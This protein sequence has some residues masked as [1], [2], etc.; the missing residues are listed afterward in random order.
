MNRLKLDFSLET[1]KERADFIEHYIIQFPDLTAKEASTI[2]DYLLWGKTDDGVALGAGVGLETKW[3]RPKEA[4]SL[5]A[6]LENPALTNIQ[7]H[8]LDDA[9]VFKKNR[10]VF[11]RK[12]ARKKAPEFLKQAFEDLWKSIDETELEINFYEERVGKREKP[13]RQELLDRFE[14]K[15]IERIRARSQKLNQYKYLKLRHKLKELRTEQFV[16]RDSY[17]PTFNITQSILTFKDKTAAFDCDIEV[18]PLGIKEGEIGEVI[19]DLNFNPDLL[20]EKQLQQISKLIWAKK[21]NTKSEK[22]T[23]DFRK[24]ESIYQLYLYREEIDDRLKEIEYDHMVENNLKNLLDTLKFYEKIADLT[25]IQREILYLKEEKTKNVDIA[26]YINKKY[27]KRYTA[28]YIS[29]I[30]KQKIVGKIVEAVE[31]HQDT[32]ENCFFKENFKKCNSCGKILLLDGRN[33]VKKTRSKDGF[34][35]KCKRCE[36]EARKKKKGE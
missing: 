20:N 29:T 10:E 22:E 5:D 32:I 31:L 9:V 4:E 1:A 17:Q 36:R 7:L 34:Q 21:E 15:E 12:E 24:P 35:N 14:D 2:A 13:P 3:T 30:F 19:F 26:D 28:N 16:L 6:V 27:G 25:D 8:S 23:F 18:L 33:W 11:S